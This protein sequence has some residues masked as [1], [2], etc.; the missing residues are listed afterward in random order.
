MNALLETILA[1]HGPLGVTNISTLE[2]VL[3]PGLPRQYSQRPMLSTYPRNKYL[4]IGTHFMHI[5]LLHTP[6]LRTFSKL[7]LNN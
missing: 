5:P 2:A 6:I 7:N 3:Y 1:N 4:H